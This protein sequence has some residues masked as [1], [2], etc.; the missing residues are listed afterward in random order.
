MKIPA[1]KKLVE[2]YT[3]AQLN[4]AAEA[5]ENESTPNIEVPG[6]DEGEQL[7]HALAAAWILERMRDGKVEFKVALREYTGMVR[8]SIS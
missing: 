1:I 8:G 2:S 3:E 6:D 5:L 4:D 7:T